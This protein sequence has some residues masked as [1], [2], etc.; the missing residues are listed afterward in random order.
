MAKLV[1]IFFWGLLISF[2]GS[3]PLGTMNVASIQITVRDG[4]QAALI[5]SFGSMFVEIFYV[6]IIVEAMGW[7]F[8]RTKVFRILGWITIF[9]LLCMAVGSFTAAIQMSGLG[10][11]LPPFSKNHFV[12]G[13]LL[14][15]LNPLHFVFWFGWSTVLLNKGILVADRLHYNLYVA[16]IGTGTIC[17]FLVFIFGGNYVVAAME[18]KQYLLNWIIGVVLVATAVIQIWKTLKVPSFVNS[19]DL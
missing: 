6:R 12:Y 7:V 14:S 1:K 11:A 8:R 17:G 19:K 5:Y 13:V 3:L 2:A 18:D 15:A 9:I 16:G 10:N 4:V